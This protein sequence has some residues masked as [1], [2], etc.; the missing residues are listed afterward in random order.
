MGYTLGV[1]G[2][3][4]I[5]LAFLEGAL[6]GAKRG[7]S[8]APTRFLASTSSRRRD[9]ELAE[10][11]TKLGVE[12][13][14]A[15]NEQIRRE[16]DVI[17][18][19]VKPKHVWSVVGH[20]ERTEHQLV[21]SLVTGLTLFALRDRV[22]P[23]TRNLSYAR[24]TTNTAASVGLAMSCLAFA[25]GALEED[26]Q[27]ATW[28]FRQLGELVVVDES[29]VDAC[30][31]LCGSAPAFTYLFA[32]A[33][34]D[35]GVKAGLP[36]DVAKKCASQVL[37]GSSEMLLRG[38]HPGVLRNAITTP[39]G[40]TINGLAVLEDHAVRGSVIKSVDVAYEVAKKITESVDSAI[41]KA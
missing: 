20:S 23:G 31:S 15:T 14:I 21:L 3:G 36:Y 34:I 4:N 16:S 13:T 22:F 11:F 26:E 1:I 35:G 27:R 8:D 38:G 39:G 17:I 33:L 19:A 41:Y 6:Q 29:N 37:K 18:L 7:D 2:C 28:I 25:E 9:K 32:E 12:V 10:Y 24:G 30:V 5:G 40:T